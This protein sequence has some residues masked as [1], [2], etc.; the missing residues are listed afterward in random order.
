MFAP[1]LALFAAAV[2]APA[3]AACRATLTGAVRADFECV[4]S[5]I[6]GEERKVFFVLR[7]TAP[8]EGIP[9]CAPGSFE[10]PA[11]PAARTY[12][13]AELGPGLASVAAEGGT[14]FTAAKTT[15]LR[16][17]VTLRLTSVAPDPARQGAWIIHGTYR[18]RLLPVGGGRTGEV[19][20]EARF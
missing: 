11:P 3:P 15:G 12:P 14:L 1:L 17:E 5:L 10:V 18:A 19:V 4:A 9:A 16:G 2:S 13:L 8:L 20:V 7:A 6:A